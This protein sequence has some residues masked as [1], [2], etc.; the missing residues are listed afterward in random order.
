MMMQLKS[1]L[2]K[3][4][5]QEYKPVP[6]KLSYLPPSQLIKM[7]HHGVRYFQDWATY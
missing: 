2:L 5:E 6:M 3:D 7:H 4:G 1:L